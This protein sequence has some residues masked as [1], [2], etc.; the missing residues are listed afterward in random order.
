MR[1]QGLPN[2]VHDHPVQRVDVARQGPLGLIVHRV[3]PLKASFTGEGQ[4]R[5]GPPVG[6]APGP[7]G[8]LPDEA[9][10]MEEGPAEIRLLHVPFEKAAPVLHRQN[11]PSGQTLDGD[12]LWGKRLQRDQ[13]RVGTT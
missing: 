11:L 9:A 6:L 2:G 4:E 12:G 7:A 3:Q 8:L 10:V 13:E 5:V 1:H